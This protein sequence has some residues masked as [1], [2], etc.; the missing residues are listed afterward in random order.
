MITF[1]SRPVIYR[2]FG[3]I[4]LILVLSG[5]ASQ[6]GKSAQIGSAKPSP[7]SVATSSTAP[8][9]AVSTPSGISSEVIARGTM[10]DGDVIETVKLTIPPGQGTGVHCHS[11]HLFAVVVAGTLTHDAPAQ[12]GGH[13][14][15]GPGSALVEG[16]GYLHQGRNEGSTPV[17]LVVTYVTPAGTPLGDTNPATCAGYPQTDPSTVATG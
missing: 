2:Y 15:F 11:G 5:C 16:S 6:N 13:Q 9:P 8:K 7:A 12:D 3:L 14:V 17:V 10:T 4:G 1:M